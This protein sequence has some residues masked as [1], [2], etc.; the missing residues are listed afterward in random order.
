MNDYSALF[1]AARA[2]LNGRLQGVLATHSLECPGY[3]FGSLVP[4]TIGPDGWPLLLLSHLAKHSRNLEAEPKCSLTLVESGEG[5]SQQLAR[6]TCLGRVTP[7][8]QP[9]DTVIER[10]FRYFPGSRM[11]HA[12]LNFHFY[13]LQ[14]ERFHFV[15]GFGAARWIG[16]EH[17]ERTP[18]LDHESELQLIRRLETGHMSALIG[19]FDALQQAD[20]GAGEPV[21]I[22]G[23]DGFGIDL[24]RGELL[25]RAGFGSEAPSQAAIEHAALSRLENTQ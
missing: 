14:P 23:I 9:A 17:L 24:R 7:L 6:L 3:P 13:R 11:Y 22:A 10:H 8:P 1:H 4:Y 12:E 21:E 18:L 25:L 2:L 19:L 16:R 20:P 15:G 5:D